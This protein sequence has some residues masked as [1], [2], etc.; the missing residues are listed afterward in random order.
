MVDFPSGLVREIKCT[1][2]CEGGSLVWLLGHQISYMDMSWGCKKRSSFPFTESIKNMCFS[3]FV[4]CQGYTEMLMKDSTYILSI[5]AKIHQQT[6][7][8]IAATKEWTNS[9]LRW[10]NPLRRNQ[11]RQ[12]DAVRPVDS[13]LYPTAKEWSWVWSFC[14]REKLK[15]QNNSR[16]QLA[17]ESELWRNPVGSWFFREAQTLLEL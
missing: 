3:M 9:L 15:P 13:A 7:A 1:H 17:L 16:K 6:S 5:H 2:L 10:T 14:V 4:Y 11:L 12:L 8:T